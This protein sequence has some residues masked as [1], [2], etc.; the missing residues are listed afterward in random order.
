MKFSWSKASKSNDILEILY[1]L[2][3]TDW[4]LAA[5]WQALPT[6]ARL[7][8]KSHQTPNPPLG[9]NPPKVWAH[10]RT[11]PVHAVLGS[12]CKAILNFGFCL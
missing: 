6:R 2:P 5:Q 3:D 9:L 4:S 8:G 11:C 10:A 1:S 7:G 12:L